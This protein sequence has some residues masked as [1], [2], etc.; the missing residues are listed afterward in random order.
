[1]E[2]VEQVVERVPST[3]AIVLLG[4]FSAPV[5]N[6]DDIWRGLIGRYSLQNMS[7]VIGNVIQLMCKPQIVNDKHLF[8]QGC[9]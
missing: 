7:S 5:W 9:S 4:D 8:K 2:K 6:D 3:N 1:M